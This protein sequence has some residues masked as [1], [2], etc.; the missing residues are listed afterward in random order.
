M[1]RLTVIAFALTLLLA[2]CAGESASESQNYA[3]QMSREHAGDTARA[4]PL[5]KPPALPVDTQRV[6]YGTVEGSAVTGYLA[7]PSNP[8][9]VAERH[10]LASGTELP[11]LIVVHEWWGLN[12]NIRAMARRLAGQGFQALAVDL[13]DDQ[14]GE[15]PARARELMQAASGDSAAQRQNT[16]AAYRF[17]QNEQNASLIGV[18]GWCFGGSVTM[19]TAL[20][21]PRKLDAA[22]IFYGQPVTDTERLSA[23]QF[24]ILG[25]FG[26]QDSSIPQSKVK[27]FRQAV[28]EINSASEVKLYENAGHAFANPSGERYVP[29]AA[30]DAWQRTVRFLS[31]QLFP[32]GAASENE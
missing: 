30:E 19:Q 18:I 32:S 2:G 31:A 17:L 15:T 28:T 20:Q 5:T 3:D 10:G 22:V 16:R 12:D 14:V 21:M 11:G 13:Y 25:L 24:P 4:T 29:E 6:Q 7:Q 9:S 1:E 27:A 8:D 26:G 23:I